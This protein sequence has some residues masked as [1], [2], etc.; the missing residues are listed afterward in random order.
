[1]VERESVDAP[2][3]QGSAVITRINRRPD[4]GWT[5]EFDLNY[6]IAVGDGREVFVRRFIR[7]RANEQRGRKGGR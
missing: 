5:V 6:R 7:V 3:S 4:G 2:D 1:M